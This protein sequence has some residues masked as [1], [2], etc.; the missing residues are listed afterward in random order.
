M[1]FDSLENKKIIALIF[2]KNKVYS[3][4]SLHVHRLKIWTEQFKQNDW[5]DEDA[6]LFHRCDVA[7]DDLTFL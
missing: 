7:S 6:A 3:F 4:K 2:W 1:L 5:P